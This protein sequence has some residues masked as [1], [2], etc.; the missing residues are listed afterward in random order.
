MRI[1]SA[2]ECAITNYEVRCLLERQQHAQLSEENALPLPGARRGQTSGSTAWQSRQQAALISDQVLIYLA[3]SCST[4]QTKESIATF[5]EAVRPFSLTYAETISLVNLQPRSVVEIYLI[6]EECEERLSHDDTT[7]LLQLCQGL[8][9][10][11]N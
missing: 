5:V 4:E 6:V 11:Q 1:I 3:E 2:R 8:R 10:I 9:A 7:K